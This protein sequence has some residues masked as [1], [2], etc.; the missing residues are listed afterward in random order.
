[1]D[2]VK[3]NGQMFLCLILIWLVVI[4]TAISS[5]MSQPFAKKQRTFWIVL[6]IVVPI[7]GLL[8]YLP[9]S[10]SSAKHNAKFGFG[11]KN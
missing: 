1:M 6:I 9:F 5:I 2:A 8:A 7:F 4:A 3:W 11:G 10:A